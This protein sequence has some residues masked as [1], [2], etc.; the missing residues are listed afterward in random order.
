M[1]TLHLVRHG[2]T[3]F[4]A[5]HRVQ[6]QHDSV[7][8]QVGI[9]QAESLRTSIEA[10]PLWSIY[11][12]SN[13]RAKRTAEILAA[14]FPLAIECLDGL[15]EIYM[16]RWQ[17]RLWQDVADTEHEQFTY[18][19]SEPHRFYVEG[20]ETFAELQT[21]GVSTIEEI[22]ST[23]YASD[24]PRHVLVVSHGAILK[25]IMAYYS[26]V[27]ISHIW[28]DPHLGNC[29]HS[30]LH[31]DTDGARKLLTVAGESVQGTI[32]DISHRD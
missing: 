27:P 22:I 11:A 29:S 14:N 31:V 13:I 28:A 20:A 32:W 8:D 30:T 16:G 12:S 10:I 24:S 3:N 1:L 18:F 9:S 25:A 5:E 19:M 23:E 21:R 17:E 2:Q 15:R 26:A 7:L 4:N 6:G